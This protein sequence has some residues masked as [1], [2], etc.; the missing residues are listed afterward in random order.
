MGVSGP[1][2]VVAVGLLGFCTAKSRAVFRHHCA[3]AL[4]HSQR[5]SLGL[6]AAN[7]H[8]VDYARSGI[9]LGLN[10]HYERIE[11]QHR[12]TASHSMPE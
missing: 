10:S 2:A 11:F 9:C 7:V 1:S 8:R 5:I 6:A 4:R 3:K 12:L